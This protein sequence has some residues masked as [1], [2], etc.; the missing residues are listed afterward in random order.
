MQQGLEQT[1]ACECRLLLTLRPEIVVE[2]R[3]ALPDQPCQGEGR[4]DIG[5]GVVRLAVLDAVGQGQPVEAQGQPLVFLGPGEALRAKGIDCPDQAQH[6]PATVALLPL[7]G[8]GIVEVA[9]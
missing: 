2:P 9:V 1:N 4:T 3:L 8:I 7:T 6:I 5:Q